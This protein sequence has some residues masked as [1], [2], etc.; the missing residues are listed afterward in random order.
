MNGQAHGQDDRG[1]GEQD[2]RDQLPVKAG[3]RC[4]HALRHQRHPLHL[5]RSPWEVKVADESPN[6]SVLGI[7]VP[8]RF[9]SVGV[10]AGARISGCAAWPL[11][12]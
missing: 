6:R 4:S 10:G 2:E 12:P 3:A 11:T 7:A 8:L 1:Q 5:Q 9:G